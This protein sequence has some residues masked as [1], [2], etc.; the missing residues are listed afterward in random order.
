MPLAIHAKMRKSSKKRELFYKDGL[1]EEN[2]MTKPCIAKKIFTLI[3][4]T[5]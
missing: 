4:I 3:N 2:Y 1:R 5:L